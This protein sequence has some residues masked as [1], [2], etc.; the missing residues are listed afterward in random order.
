[1]PHPRASRATFRRCPRPGFFSETQP[2]IAFFQ[3]RKYLPSNTPPSLEFRRRSLVLNLYV[4]NIWPNSLPFVPGHYHLFLHQEQTRLERGDVGRNDG[5]ESHYLGRSQE[6][7]DGKGFEADCGGV[8]RKKKA[9]ERSY[10]LISMVSKTEEGEK[11]YAT[12]C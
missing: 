5:E 9:T 2:S 6:S 11:Q 1:M 8:G 12:R 4:I 3:Q 7:K 10:Q